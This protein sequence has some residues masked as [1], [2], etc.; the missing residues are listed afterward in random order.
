MAIERKRCA[1]CGSYLAHDH[2]AEQFCS[3]CSDKLRELNLVAQGS[4]PRFYTVEEYAQ[5]HQIEAEQ[6]R[7]KCRRKEILAIKPGRRWLIPRQRVKF[8]MPWGTDKGLSSATDLVSLFE[9]RYPIQEVVSD[10]TQR[11]LA[12]V[13]ATAVARL[14]GPG[15]VVRHVIRV[16]RD[17]PPPTEFIRGI[18]AH[19]GEE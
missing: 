9:K 12:D 18:K 10:L 4:S 15:E 3:P 6:V 8:A 2:S 19:L 1:L 17:L 13:I 16:S 5:E 11:P 14:P 7:R